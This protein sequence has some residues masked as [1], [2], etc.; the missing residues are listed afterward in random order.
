MPRVFLT[1][2]V[3]VGLLVLPGCSPSETQTP[4][5]EKNSE[6]ADAKLTSED[7]MSEA[8]KLWKK[9]EILEDEFE[10]V[11]SAE[12]WQKYERAA[13]KEAEKSWRVIVTYPD[14][15]SVREV[16]EAKTNLNSIY[17]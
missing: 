6:C 10:R 9:V 14:C 8:K 1:P 15:F 2:F 3:I 13:L 5:G 11:G 7:Y 12:S 16:I 17:D 4:I